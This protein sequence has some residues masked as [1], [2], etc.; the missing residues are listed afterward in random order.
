VHAGG[1]GAADAAL[2][3]DMGDGMVT[4]KVVANSR[5]KAR[6]RANRFSLGLIG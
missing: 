6:G 1:R 2:W 5:I 4:T 3:P